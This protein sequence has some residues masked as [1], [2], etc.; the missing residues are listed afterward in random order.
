MN[1]KIN[2]FVFDLNIGTQN[3]LDIADRYNRMAARLE[4]KNLK[5]QQRKKR[6][7]LVDDYNNGNLSLPELI[8][9]LDDTEPGAN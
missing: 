5:A 8:Q 3:F 9:A 1:D 7:E 4:A 2:D 6:R